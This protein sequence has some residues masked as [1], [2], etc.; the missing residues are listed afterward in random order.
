[1]NIAVTIAE[2][3]GSSSL[4]SVS[5]DKAEYMPDFR[6]QKTIEYALNKIIA[7]G[8]VHYLWGGGG[9]GGWQMGKRNVWNFLDPPS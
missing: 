9:G 4:A 6:A 5:L 7:K 3:I 2:T 1:M 8:S